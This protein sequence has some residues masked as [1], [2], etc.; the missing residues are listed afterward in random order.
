VD[1]DFVLDVGD[2]G[3][4]ASG[5]VVQDYWRIALGQQGIT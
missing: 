4:L 5:K 1:F 2:V 3:Q